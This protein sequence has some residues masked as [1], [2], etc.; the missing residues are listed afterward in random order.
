MKYI[1]TLL[2]FISSVAFAN[3]SH[4]V[5]VPTSSNNKLYIDD[6]NALTENLQGHTYNGFK[7]RIVFT[8]PGSFQGT[9]MTT[10]Y[11]VVSEIAEIVYD[12]Q[13]QLGIGKRL[14]FTDDQNTEHTIDDTW[15]ELER[16]VALEL[17]AAVQ[18]RVC[19]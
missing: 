7:V 3:P 4:W 12:C 6:A 17:K 14:Q 18:A 9:G 13:Q 2:L 8:T 11:T 15:R 5:E 1:A 16:G 10:T 19:N